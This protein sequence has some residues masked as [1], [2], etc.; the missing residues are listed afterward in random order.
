[1]SGLLIPAIR[2]EAEWIEPLK[3][4]AQEEKKDSVESAKRVAEQ[5]KE[6]AQEEAQR[7]GFSS[8]S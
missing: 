7:Q 2:Q 5:A 4:S 3:E 8:E 6:A 1:M